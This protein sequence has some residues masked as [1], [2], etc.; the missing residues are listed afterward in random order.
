MGYGDFGA[1]TVSELVLT[2]IWMIFGVSFYAYV[3]G[4]LTSIIANEN[5]N[6]ENLYNRL[7]ALEEFAK[8]TK[9]PEDLLFKIKNF[10]ENNYNELFSQQDE[11]QLL[12]ELP[13]S[14]R[15]D[16]LFHRYEG[17]IKSIELLRTW[18]EN[19]N[20]FVWELVPRL[21]KIKM[22]KDDTIY[23]EG[24]FS[25]EIYFIKTG[26]V[27]LVALNGYAFAYYTEG[28][29]FGDNDVI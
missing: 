22:E 15:E 16:V 17:L 11:E 18:N 26:K 7:K 12:A 13:A 19:N 8:K 5:D 24:D 25:E 23:R 6:A 10:L 3:I 14:L 28:M 20:E 2:F 21:K 27:K 1:Q 4:N 9:L 29:H